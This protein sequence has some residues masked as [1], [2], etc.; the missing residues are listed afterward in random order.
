MDISLSGAEIALIGTLMASITSPLAY[1]AKRLLD[2]KDRQIARLE[3][4]NQQL[5]DMALSGTKAVETATT[6]LRQRGGSR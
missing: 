2:D 3:A 4:Q 1:L 5:L 6:V